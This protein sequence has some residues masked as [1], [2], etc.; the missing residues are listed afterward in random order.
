MSSV[1][2]VKMLRG[3]GHRERVVTPKDEARY[4]TAA[5]EPL[6]SIAVVLADT[7]SVRK[8]VSA[9]DGNRSHGPM[10]ASVPCL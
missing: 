7:A 10:D 1:P 8:S 5:P 9:L 2:K 6:A 4:L 3:E